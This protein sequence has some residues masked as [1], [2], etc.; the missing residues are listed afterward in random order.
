MQVSRCNPDSA[1]VLPDIAQSSRWKCR[2]R[3]MRH[4][5][6]RTIFSGN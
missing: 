6:Y 1:A 4:W 3:V 2:L 5:F